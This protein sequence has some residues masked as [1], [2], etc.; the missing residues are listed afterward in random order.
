MAT[1]SNTI[2]GESFVTTKS[3]QGYVLALLVV[4]GI[5]AWTD[6]NVLSILLESIRR[7]FDFS[8][9]QLGLLG[10]VAFGLFYA[11]L[12]L[13]VAW[14]ADRYNRVTLISVAIAIWSA[15]TALCGLATGFLTLFLARVGVGIGEA[16]ASPP[17]QSLISDYFPPERRAFALGIFYLYV[18]LGFV[19][20][21]LAGG[22]L[23]ELFDWRVAFA[24]VGLPGLLLA[25]LT[26]LTLAEPPR[27]LSERLGDSGETPSLP[28]TIRYC[29]SRPS[30]RHLPL[31]GAI[32]GI[33]SF[34][35]AVWLPSYFIRAYGLSSGKVGTWMA[36]AYGLGGGVGVLAGGYLADKLA[37]RKSDERWYPWSCAIYILAA[38]PFAGVVYLTDTPTT[39]FIALVA[40]T[41]FTQMF[42]GPVT[43]IMQGLAG[44]RRRAVVA[45]FYLFLVNLISTGVGPL[46]VG[47]VSDHFGARFGTDSLRYALLLIVLV[48]SAW[49]A[50]H[51]ALAA[52]HV[53]KDLAAARAS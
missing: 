29:W 2:G 49:S 8:D 37:R 21:F 44:L 48:T 42:L 35:A 17:A 38:A 33:G 4:I 32:H 18:P 6:R 45:A 43:A 27:G 20:G 9:S 15:A 41:L 53:R 40:A 51:F 36:V 50:V 13:P 12:G 47:M 1:L 24:V 3:R 39:A 11:T 23:N 26:R 22:W 31:A 34:A 10:G 19:V 52:R 30:L 5:F 46:V 28:A 14:M 7:D 25:A 16:G